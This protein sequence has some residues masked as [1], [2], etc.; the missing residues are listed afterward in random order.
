[1]SENRAMNSRTLPSWLVVEMN[2]NSVALIAPVRPS[3][4]A[5]SAA[6]ITGHSSSNPSTL[7]QAGMSSIA[8]T[9]RALRARHGVPAASCFLSLI[10]RVFS[11][12]WMSASLHRR[13]GK[14]VEKLL[15]HEHADVLMEHGPSHFEGRHQVVVD[16]KRAGH[17]HVEV[18]LGRRVRVEPARRPVLETQIAD[19]GGGIRGLLRCK[20]S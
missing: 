2:S 18:G 1:M 8:I 6:G 12:C 11:P 5:V 20:R 16:Q 13:A 3:R 14:R 9:S 17:R 19:A 10:R 4:V 7:T 15:G